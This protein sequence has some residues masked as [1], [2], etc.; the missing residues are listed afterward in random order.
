MISL[1]PWLEHLETHLPVAKAG[2]DPK[3]VH[4]VRVAGRRLRVWLELAGL[5]VL[6]D[7]LAW[8][9]RGAGKVRDLEV[10]LGYPRLPQPF[11]KW[12]T[13]RL[14]EA[15]AELVPMLESPRLKGLLRA[16]PTLPPLEG[17]TEARLQGFVRRVERRAREW[18]QHDQFQQ[19]HALRRALRKLRYAREWLGLPTEAIKELQDALGAVGDITFIL[20][21]LAMFE[22]NGNKAPAQLRARLKARLEETLKTAKDVWGAHGQAALV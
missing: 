20:N 1:V 10:L 2:A 15:R 4:Q 6:E 17:A 12:A 19:L 14:V 9:V 11:R 22:G 21:Y 7:D 13:E 5:R 18:E 8:L 16:L 3:G